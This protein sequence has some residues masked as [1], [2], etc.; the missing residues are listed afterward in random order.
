MGRLNRRRRARDLA[1]RI[2]QPLAAL[3]RESRHQLLRTPNLPLSGAYLV[4]RER[5]AAFRA[6]VA[7][8]D[9]EID[10]AEV[11]CTGPWPPYSFVKGPAESA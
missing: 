10:Q 5:L 3:A 6:R 4:E 7:E 11:I 9:E 1:E 8:L 2:D